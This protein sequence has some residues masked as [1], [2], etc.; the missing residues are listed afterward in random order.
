MLTA[1][2]LAPSLVM[3]PDAWH[4]DGFDWCGWDWCDHYHA[5][6]EGSAPELLPAYLVLDG[7]GRVYLQGNAHAFRMLCARILAAL[8]TTTGLALLADA[9]AHHAETVA[10]PPALRL[11]R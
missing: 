3:S 4:A 1:S 9:Q 11:V 2:S 7:E 5:S 6:I 8:P 10:A